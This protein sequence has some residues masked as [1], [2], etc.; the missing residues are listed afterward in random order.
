MMASRKMRD[1]IQFDD[2]KIDIT[3]KKLMVISV[4]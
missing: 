2:M 4:S 1:Q 3:H